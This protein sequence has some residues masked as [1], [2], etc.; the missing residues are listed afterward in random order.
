MPFNCLWAE[1]VGREVRSLD[2]G[3]GEIKWQPTNI[4]EVP[5]TFYTPSPRIC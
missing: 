1:I 3:K 2:E 5:D 4:K